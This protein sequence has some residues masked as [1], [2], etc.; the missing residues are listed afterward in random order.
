[1]IVKVA[2]HEIPTALAGGRPDA[3]RGAVILNGGDVLRLRVGKY[4]AQ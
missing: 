3:L 4:A 2:T 1:M